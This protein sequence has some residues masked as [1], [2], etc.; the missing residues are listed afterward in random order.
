[1]WVERDAPYTLSGESTSE[2]KE[3]GNIT[4]QGTPQFVQRDG[5]SDLPKSIG[6]YTGIGNMTYQE[7]TG[8]GNMTYQEISQ[9]ITNG[10]AT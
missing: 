6:G 5:Q 8:M 9:A 7:Y 1:M 2:Y 3:V 4:Y 10:W